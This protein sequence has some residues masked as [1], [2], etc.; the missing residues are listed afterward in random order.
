MCG[1]SRARL[2]SAPLMEPTRISLRARRTAVFATVAA[3]A[4]LALP[5][6]AGAAVTGTVTGNTATLTGDGADDN[7]AIG[8]T[9]ANLSHNLAGFNSAI[10]FDSVA[11]GDQTLTAT[12]GLTINSNA[13]ADTI[14]GGPGDDTINGGTELDPID[15][16]G[17]NDRITGGPGGTA[18][19]RE[20][21]EGNTG[22]D[23]ML[24]N[25]GDGF[26]LNDGDAGVDESVMVNGAANDQ[27]SVSPIAGG[28]TLFDRT[29]NPFNVDMGT[30]EKLSIASFAGNDTLTTAAGVT[31][32]MVVDAGPGA[33]DITTGGST[34]RIVGDRG[35]DILNGGSGD[36]TLVWGNGD[37]DDEMNGQDGLDRIENNLG[38]ADDVSN[39]TVVGGNVHYE[40]TNA[41]FNLDI[42]TSEVLELNTFG[43]ND[44]LNVGAGVGALIAITAD[45]GSGDDSFKGGDEAD[46]FFGGLGDDV[47]DPG[48]GADTVDGQ[49]GA[50]TLMVRDGAPDLAR[51]GAG[52]DSAQ[53]DAIDALDGIENAD[54][55]AAPA[56]PVAPAIDSK[57]TA[58][59]VL[60][61]T[62]TSRLRNGIYTARVRVECPVAELGGCRGT[63]SLLTAK[64]VRIGGVR[65]QALLGSK[66]T[67]LR[68]G[69]RR[70][71][72]IKLP[73][74]VG[75]FANRSRTLKL[76]AQT[77]SRDATGNQASRA[78]SFSVKLRK[79]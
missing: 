12:A 56:A 6:M 78:S 38:G 70:T 71:L 32:P 76:R 62:I 42:A 17:G 11:A 46:T 54:V 44:T 49:D 7:I 14:A 34:D 64:T 75:K 59:R 1:N 15:G 30:I 77:V 41:P 74:G 61:R 39:V 27:M 24:W 68:P 23:V 9:G 31:V 52:T 55:L 47:L 36:D 20:P 2:T 19:D 21:I 51:G 67:T 69:Q 66:S 50:D 79:K 3:A 57:A 22:N 26:D 10:D 16:G 28:R 8:V 5:S 63:L 40:R 53:A 65:V 37:G 25:N 72:A 48:A 60:G 73:R 18:L 33:D 35:N 13:G 45:A 4:A 58:M 29:N 43:G